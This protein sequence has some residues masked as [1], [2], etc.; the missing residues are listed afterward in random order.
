MKMY[1]D[2]RKAQFFNLFFYLPLPDIFRAFFKPIFR[3]SRALTPS[4]GHKTHGPSSTPA[5][6]DG[7][8]ESPKHVRQK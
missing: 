8:K 1:N 7:L 6:E 5:P 3:G 4:P 2:Q